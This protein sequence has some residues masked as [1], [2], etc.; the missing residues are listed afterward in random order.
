VAAAVEAWERALAAT[1][2]RQTGLRAAIRQHLAQAQSE[3]PQ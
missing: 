3:H 1:T 2:D